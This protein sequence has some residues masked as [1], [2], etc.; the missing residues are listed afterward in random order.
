MF[1]ASSPVELPFSARAEGG[2]EPADGER[3]VS[4]RT[5]HVF[6]EWLDLDPTQGDVSVV[7]DLSVLRAGGQESRGVIETRLEPNV[8]S[9]IGLALLW[10]T[11]AV[12]RPV[13]F[14]V[15]KW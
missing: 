14:P 1:N 2:P 15:I 9:W 13:V 10:D 8:E 5:G 11:G 4:Y 6:N 12:Y 7:V 3:R